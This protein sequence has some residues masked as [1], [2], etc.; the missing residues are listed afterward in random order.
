M[1]RL[2]KSLT[3]PILFI[4]D[5]RKEDWAIK[6]KG[7]DLGPRKELIKEFSKNTDNLFYS[8]TTA[9]F[10]QI[11]SD[12]YKITN[13]KK[14]QE[15]TESIQ[16]NIQQKENELRKKEREKLE[17]LSLFDKIRKLNEIQ[18]YNKKLEV[19]ENLRNPIDEF[20]NNRELIE[21]V[22]NPLEEFHKAREVYEN[23]RN[24]MEEFN[25]TRE[26][27]ERA[28]NPIEELNKTREIME[29]LRD[30]MKP[31]REAQE[32]LD[33]LRKSKDKEK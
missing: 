13:T 11:I 16:R 29:T 22:K 21:K 7:Y 15:E 25:R 9:K 30:P 14:L 4:S 8:I 33:A 26:I 20:N 1:Q 19:L 3:K 23:F 28:K 6:F 24:P 10:I 5:D 27:I 32:Y 2:S 17:Y 31:Y 12:S 18:D